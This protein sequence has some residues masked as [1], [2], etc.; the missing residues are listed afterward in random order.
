MVLDCAAAGTLPR[1]LSG[2]NQ[3]LHSF[4]LPAVCYPAE[5]MWKRRAGSGR[6]GKVRSSH[7]QWEKVPFFQTSA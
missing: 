1:A 7:A 6:A 3:N 2:A 5:L 4:V